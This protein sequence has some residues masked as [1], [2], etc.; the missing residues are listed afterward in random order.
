MKI[1]GCV[2]EVPQTSTT[3]NP[4]TYKLHVEGEGD[5]FECRKALGIM[6]SALDIKPVK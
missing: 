1:T 5:E 2:Y 6:L 3:V 4:R